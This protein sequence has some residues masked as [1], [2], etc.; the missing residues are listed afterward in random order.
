MVRSAKKRRMFLSLPPQM[1]V[2]AEFSGD[3][4][5]DSPEAKALLGNVRQGERRVAPITNASGLVGLAGP[6][7]ARQGLKR[8]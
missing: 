3:M 8:S 7:P 4:L 2:K 6:E 1:Q 5:A